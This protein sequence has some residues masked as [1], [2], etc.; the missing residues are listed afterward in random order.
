MVQR[1]N[2]IFLLKIQNVSYKQNFHLIVLSFFFL[3]IHFVV[4]Q[5]WLWRFCKTLH[6]KNS[7][8]LTLT[9]QL[10][11]QGRAMIDTR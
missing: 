9:G 3:K 5:S 10:P 11:C 7:A 1:E 4:Y 2:Q 6:Q 8:K